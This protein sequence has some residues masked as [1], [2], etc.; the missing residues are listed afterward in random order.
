M[1]HILSDP[2]LQ[3]RDWQRVFAFFEEHLRAPDAS[4]AKGQAASDGR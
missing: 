4:T 3:V 1:T 2:S